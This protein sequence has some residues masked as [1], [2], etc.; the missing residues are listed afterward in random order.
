[1]KKEEIIFISS[2]TEGYAYVQFS[3]RSYGYVDHNMIII[4]KGLIDA[5]P[6]MNGY[7][8]VQFSCN[9]FGR[10]SKNLRFYEEDKKTL[11]KNNDP[12]LKGVKVYNLKDKLNKIL[13]I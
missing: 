4:V 6:F 10:L 8:L 11:I 9:N 5:Y 2:Y 7:A 13:C 3:D 12:R 1:M